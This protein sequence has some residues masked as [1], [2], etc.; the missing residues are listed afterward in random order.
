MGFSSSG[1]HRFG[2]EILSLE[3]DF[4]LKKTFICLLLHSKIHFAFGFINLATKYFG[5][6]F[7]QNL[8]QLPA[9]IG[10]CLLPKTC[11]F[12]LLFFSRQHFLPSLLSF[13]FL[14]SKDLNVETWAGSMSLLNLVLLWQ[15]LT[16]LGKFSCFIFVV[17]FLSVA[18]LVLLPCM[19][20]CLACFKLAFC[21]FKFPFSSTL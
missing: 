2:K 10:S 20:A 16:K 3:N 1:L 9:S 5:L 8:I 17:H 14:D 18:I 4:S 12:L 6:N 21:I 19:K 15:R 7:S 11:V 13:C